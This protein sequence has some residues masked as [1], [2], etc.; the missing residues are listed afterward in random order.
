[1]CGPL[2]AG[3]ALSLPDRR[4]TLPHLLFNLGRVVTYAI[5]GG[6]VGLTGSFVRVVPWIEPVQRV[7][8]GITGILVALMGLSAGGWIPGLRRIEPA[9]PFRGP[10]GAVA[11]RV[12]EAGGPG[13]SFP[14][15][16]AAGL[17]PC[18]LVYTA[19]LSAAGTGMGGNSPAE[20]FLRGFLAMAAFGA[21]TFPALFL[22]GKAVGLAGVRL[23]GIL[24]RGAAL[25]LVAGGGLFAIRAIL[26]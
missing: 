17:L 11:R 24:A 3:Y 4:A 26:G 21:G 20:G 7:V 23:R 2:V 1:M 8:L 12:A 6:I 14:L 16:L 9:G 25:L 5:A 19:L 22:F 18:G 13:A 10:I 15:G